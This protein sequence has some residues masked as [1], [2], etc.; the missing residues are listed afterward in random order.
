[1][2][3]GSLTLLVL[4]Q[5]VHSQ[6]TAC[7]WDLRNEKWHSGEKV[8]VEKN[9]RPEKWTFYSDTALRLYYGEVY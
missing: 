5:T 6:V 4:L 1:M 2:L 3:Q 8:C 9:G 7:Y